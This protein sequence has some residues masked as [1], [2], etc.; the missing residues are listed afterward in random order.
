MGCSSVIGHRKPPTYNRWLGSSQE[1]R[2][3]CHGL[4]NRGLD[5]RDDRGRGFELHSYHFLATLLLNG[6][7]RRF[8]IHIETN[9]DLGA[10]NPDVPF[11]ATDDQ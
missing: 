6:L 5:D 4:C 11:G 3:R 10:G 9:T 7:L 8:G 1:F 2:G